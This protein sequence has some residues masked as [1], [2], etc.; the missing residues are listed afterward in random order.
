MLQ[1]AFTS[2]GVR[3]WWTEL[4]AK[5]D[6][7][8]AS[9]VC[10]LPFLCDRSRKAM[11][12]Q[13][14]FVLASTLPSNYPSLIRHKL[15]GVSNLVIQVADSQRVATKNITTLC[16]ISTSQAKII[17]LLGKYWSRHL[18][19]FM[20]PIGAEEECWHPISVI[21]SDA[22]C[23]FDIKPSK[24]PNHHVLTLNMAAVKSVETLDNF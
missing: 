7:M 5:S 8:K 10:C 11:N 16:L 13:F 17:Q 4:Q 19:D 14:L 2:P 6:W 3:W 18:Q 1:V 22:H 9:V 24:T 21:K 20:V 12:E 15:S 23:P